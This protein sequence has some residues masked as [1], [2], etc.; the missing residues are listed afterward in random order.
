MSGGTR[1]GS[2]KGQPHKIYGSP[3]FFQ[4]AN[5]SF[6]RIWLEEKCMFDA[7]YTNSCCTVP[8]NVQ[9]HVLFEVR[10]NTKPKSL[11]L[12]MCFR[13][14]SL[15]L[16][17]VKKTAPWFMTSL[18]HRRRIEREAKGKD[19]RVCLGGI[20]FVQFLAALAVLPRLVWKN[21]MN[22]TISTPSCSLVFG[23]KTKPAL[24]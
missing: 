12:N 23:L 17:Y 15:N 3:F 10:T 6:I 7:N 18:L 14:W 19:R 1:H 11:K 13:I 9:L 24:S 2:L 8:N 21:R 5:S 22:S 16:F 20:V 4:L